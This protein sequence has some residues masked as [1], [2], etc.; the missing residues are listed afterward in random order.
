MHNYFMLLLR[1]L[2]SHAR[3]ML[4]TIMLTHIE[5]IVVQIPGPVK[6][7]YVKQWVWCSMMVL[8]K[9]LPPSG[10]VYSINPDAH[11]KFQRECFLDCEESV[12]II[13]FGVQL[14]QASKNLC[15]AAKDTDLEF[16]KKRHKYGCL[17]FPGFL[18][19]IISSRS[20]IFL[21]THSL[22]WTRTSLM[23]GT[24]SKL[25]V[26]CILIVLLIVPT[27]GLQWL[28]LRKLPLV[29]CH[30]TYSGLPICLLYLLAAKPLCYSWWNVGE[31]PSPSRYLTVPPRQS[32]HHG[33]PMSPAPGTSCLAEEARKRGQSRS[34]HDSCMCPVCFFCIS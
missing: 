17:N 3:P 15:I 31:S 18:P 23:Q 34:L 9:F 25:P 24:F 28:H 7:K 14:N 12:K 10:E 21:M 11:L 32:R 8:Q 30:F 27:I 16:I 26:C 1:E 13:P 6:P 20:M 22:P 4:K 33:S 29:A 19:I 2:A 5:A